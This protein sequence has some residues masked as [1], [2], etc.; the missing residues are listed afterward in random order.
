M[1]P[2]GNDILTL[3]GITAFIVVAIVIAIIIGSSYVEGTDK[4]RFIG[5][6]LLV[7]GLIFL[8]TLMILVT[9]VIIIQYDSWV[10]WFLI[11]LCILTPINFSLGIIVLLSYYA[12][13]R[14]NFL[15]I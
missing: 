11:P 4:I 8:V 5:E 12:F 14:N 2:S 15:T 9:L 3:V 1:A 7:I 6:F 13:S 10:S